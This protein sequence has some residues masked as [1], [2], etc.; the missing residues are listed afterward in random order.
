MMW[1]LLLIGGLMALVF[2]VDVA[3][4]LH[5]RTSSALRAECARTAPYEAALTAACVVV[6]LANYYLGG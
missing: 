5:P 1:E 4:L 6:A 3:L 2:A